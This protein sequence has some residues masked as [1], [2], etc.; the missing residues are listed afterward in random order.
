MWTKNEIEKTITLVKEGKNYNEISEITGRPIN[1][2]RV[3]LGKL[4]ETYSKHNQKEIK[5]CLNC[6][7]EIVNTGTKFCSN[8]CSATY[9]NKLRGDIVNCLYCN[10]IINSDDRQRRKYCNQ[11]CFNGHKEQLIFENIESGNHQS[12]DTRIYK[13]Y[14]IKL[15]GEKC[16]E[17]GWCEVNQH[18][19]NIPLEL[20]HVD[21][22]PDN[23]KV[24]NLQLL[25]PNCHSLTKN[26]KGMTKGSGRYSRRRI[27]RRVDYNNG[28]AT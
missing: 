5:K 26:W 21:F 2:I 8:S 19:G 13:K 22:N 15:H 7:K 1:A 6:K 20:H 17:C 28:K 27:K 14:L 9:N 12:M 10:N 24:D 16:M 18:S 4:G 23:N 25:C 11:S 3:K